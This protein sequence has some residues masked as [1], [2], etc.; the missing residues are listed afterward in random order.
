MPDFYTLYIVPINQLEEITER[1]L[2]FVFSK[3]AMDSCKEPSSFQENGRELVNK[4]AMKNS[5]Y[6]QEI[7]QS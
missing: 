5:E 6:D 3:G 1:Q 4:H 2:Y 7:P